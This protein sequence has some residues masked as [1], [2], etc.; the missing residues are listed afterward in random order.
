M[1]ETV[2]V[3]FPDSTKAH[4]FRALIRLMRHSGLAI[5][6]A[7]TLRRDELIHNSSEKLRSIVTARQKTGTH[8][9]APIPPDVAK[10]LLSVLNGNPV[11]FFWT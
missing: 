1:L 8:V 4:R 9:S 10:E 5:R 2:P 7:E 6:D 3:S 11:Y